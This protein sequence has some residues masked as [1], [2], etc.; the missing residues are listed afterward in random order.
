M[1]VCSCSSGIHITNK[2][3]QSTRSRSTNCFHESN[4]CQKHIFMSFDAGKI[5]HSPH[6]RAS[7]VN[8]PYNKQ[9]SLYRKNPLNYTHS[10]NVLTLSQIKSRARD[11]WKKRVTL[12]LQW[13]QEQI[14]II[15]E[16]WRQVLDRYFDV[17]KNVLRGFCFR[18]GL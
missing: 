9:S 15:M 11:N 13:S 14:C 8:Y 16:R 5:N 6:N 2:V 4:I 10:I 17:F 1:A 7:I 18:R 3:E 12:F